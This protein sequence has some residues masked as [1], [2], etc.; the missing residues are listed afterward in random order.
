MIWD[1]SITHQAKKEMRNLSDSVLKN[2]NRKILDLSQNPFPH[3]AI[4]LKLGKG[5][6]IRVSDWRIVYTVDKTELLITIYRVIHRS[7]AYKRAQ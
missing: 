2:V 5:Y 7:K 1:I 6:R 4:K 3:G